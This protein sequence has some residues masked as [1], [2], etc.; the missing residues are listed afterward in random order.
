MFFT[1]GA[2]KIKWA[3]GINPISANCNSINSLNSINYGSGINSPHR[4]TIG[5][6]LNNE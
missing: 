5:H 3:W 1:G 2:I 6:Q 4:A